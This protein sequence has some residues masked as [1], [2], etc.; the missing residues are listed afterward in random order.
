MR[1]MERDRGHPGNTS[2][3]RRFF[4]YMRQQIVL[5]LQEYGSNQIHLGPLTKPDV[6]ASGFFVLGTLR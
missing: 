3:R 2:K 5:I 1:R 6:K 4:T